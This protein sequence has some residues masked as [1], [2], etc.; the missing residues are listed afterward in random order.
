MRVEVAVGN[1]AEIGVGL[2]GMDRDRHEGTNIFAGFEV[3]PAL[4]YML[5]LI[6]GMGAIGAGTRDGV[7]LG[8]LELRLSG[9]GLY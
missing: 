2:R 5:V 8:L 1:K 3:S 9:L 7:E 4:V 6:R